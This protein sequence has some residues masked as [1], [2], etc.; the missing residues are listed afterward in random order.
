MLKISQ[1]TEFIAGLIILHASHNLSQILSSFML[2]WIKGMTVN[3]FDF[4]NE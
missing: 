2:V 4:N 3:N 1:K